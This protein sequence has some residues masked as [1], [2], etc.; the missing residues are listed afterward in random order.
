M[1]NGIV[2][3]GYVVVY[4]TIDGTE[5]VS[6]VVS[7]SDAESM[8]RRVAGRIVS[9]QGQPFRTVRGMRVLTDPARINS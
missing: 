7:K 4:R 5:K 3:R 1:S 6:A 9:A 2:S 8:R